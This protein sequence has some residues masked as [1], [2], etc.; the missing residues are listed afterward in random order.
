MEKYDYANWPVARRK[1]LPFFEQSIYYILAGRVLYSTRRRV[2]YSTRRRVLYSTRRRVL[3]STRRCPGN[4]RENDHG[5]VLGP[6][7]RSTAT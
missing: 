1:K 3:Y 6:S 4:I 7:L 2:L 5:V